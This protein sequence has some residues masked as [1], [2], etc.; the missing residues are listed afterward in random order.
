[1]ERFPPE[2]NDPRYPEWQRAYDRLTEA[3]RKLQSVNFMPQSD[4]RFAAA[5]KEWM[6]AKVAY[7]ALCARL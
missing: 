4:P 6:E 1:M 7:E 5:D 2:E 3:V